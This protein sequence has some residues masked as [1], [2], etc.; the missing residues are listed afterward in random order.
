MGVSILKEILSEYGINISNE[1]AEKLSFY[2]EKLLK[3]PFNLTSI[4]DFR[5]A[6]H[7]HVADVL[8]PVRNIEGKLLDIG[9]GSGVVGVVL[10]A[11]FPIE[12]V[13]LDSSSKKIAWLRRI[14]ES[15]ELP[16]VP[17][18]RR[19]EHYTKVNRECFDFVSA[20]AVAPLNI[21]CE[22]SSASCKVGGTLLFYKGSKWKEELK[23]A[24]NALKTLH[25]EI[26]D[27]VEYHLITNEKRALLKL[28]KTAP[29]P[30]CY[31]RRCGIPRKRPL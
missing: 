13:L 24:E 16:V 19:A 6:V 8:L 12:A 11:I 17:I 7:K 1:A 22:I 3:A 14:T 5:T 21:L 26:L 9:T 10:C 20:R 23:E 18:K 2:I 29:T 31:P 28:R 30:D 27:V 4:S 15:I 25:L